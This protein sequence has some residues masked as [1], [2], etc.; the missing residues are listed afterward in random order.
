MGTATSN[1]A[2]Y[3]ALS[4]PLR[5]ELMVL[6]EAL[7]E[8]VVAELAEAVGRPADRLY[9]HVHKLEKAGL[10]RAI[11]TRAAPRRDQT[12]YALVPEAVDLRADPSEADQIERMAS[13]MFRYAL[14]QF[15]AT[16]AAGELH[17]EKPRR[18]GT[19]RTELGWLNQQQRKAV[20]QHMDGIREIFAQSRQAPRKGE[21]SL[22]VLMLTPV[23]PQNDTPS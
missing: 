1:T 18:N 23:Q 8:A 19:F 7:G 2:V 16:V 9:H 20:L 21:K 5:A 14:K 12:V 13:L 11:G 6:M 10:I 17:Q 4:S 22:S 3:D 15:I